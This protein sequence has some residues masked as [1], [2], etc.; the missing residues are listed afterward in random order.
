M[1]IDLK[2]AI[3]KHNLS[4]KGVIHVGAN[5]GQEAD[6]YSDLGLEVVWIEAI[7]EVCEQLNEHIGNYKN[8][9]AVN[10]CIGAENGIAKVFHISNNEAQSSS[11]LELGTHIQA[12]PDVYYVSKFSTQTVRIDSL[13]KGMCIDV[14][15]HWLLVAD[16]QGAEMDALIGCGDLLNKFGCVYLEVNTQHLYEGCALKH[17]IENYLAH[18]K[19]VPVEEFIYAHWGWGDEFFIRKNIL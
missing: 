3:A 13:L 6:I 9:V 12:H 1:L 8:Q 2:Q 10:A 5:K 7:P 19:F 17:E 11:Y 16:I 15:E 14:D 4:L 18:Y